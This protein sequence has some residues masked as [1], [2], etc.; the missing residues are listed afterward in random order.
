MAT[1]TARYRALYD[2]LREQSG[3][4]AGAAWDGLAE[5]TDATVEEYLARTVPL[6]GAAQLQ[7]ATLT[8]GY[9]AVALRRAPLGI[10]P[11]LVTGAGLRGTSLEQVYTRPFLTVWTELSRG[12]SPLDAIAAGRARAVL[13]ARTD[14][15]LAARAATAEVGKADPNIKSF[16]R[17]VSGGGCAVCSE[18][19]G[20]DIGDSELMPLHPNCGC[21]AEP[22]TDSGPQGGGTG[23]SAPTAPA[24]TEVA[25]HEHGE[26]GPVL[27]PAGQEF[28]GEHDI[29][30]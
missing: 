17:T 26:L 4:V 8:D 10:D 30:E 23:E 28:T 14:V 18:V 16:S 20:A 21:T 1:L 11:E 15:A 22:V 3:N 6:V 29:E 24:G 27:Y 25:V 5:Y 9:I 2:Q 7:A 19:D 12:R 13:A